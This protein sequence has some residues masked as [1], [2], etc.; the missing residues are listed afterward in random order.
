MKRD[1]IHNNQK[2]N[3]G[4]MGQ[5]AVRRLEEHLAKTIVWIDKA[6]RVPN[7]WKRLS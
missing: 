7:F 4:Q 1:S 6:K 3:C 5:A 2:C